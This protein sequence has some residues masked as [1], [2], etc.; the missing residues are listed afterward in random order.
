MF[1]ISN[2]LSFIED[3]EEASNVFTRQMDRDVK[4][5]QKIYHEN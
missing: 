2:L 4:I 3:C 1:N 5:K